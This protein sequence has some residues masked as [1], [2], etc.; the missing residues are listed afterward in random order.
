M[1]A[2]MVV[3]TGCTSKRR[4]DSE[5]AIR[6]S[7]IAEMQDE[8]R[9]MNDEIAAREDELN[10]QRA[11]L[12]L[13]DDK[14]DV[15]EEELARLQREIDALGNRVGTEEQRVDMLNQ[16]LQ[17]VLGDLQQKEKLWLQEKEGMSTITMPNAATFASGST[18]LT[19]EGRAIIDTIWTVLSKYP[20]RDVFIE[21]HTDSIPIGPALRRRFDSNWELSAAR[22]VAVLRYVL[23][24]HEAEAGR[25]GAVGYGEHHP[26]ASNS[27]EETRTLNRRVV[28]SVRPER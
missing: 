17:R 21:G 5:I 2:M 7:T 26:V 28:I 14:I 15:K 13:R 23:S 16:D 10:R 18:A 11:E 22:A 9:R 27:T 6:E 1:V 25:L 4:M 12:S 24:N 3:L 8:V 20:D 19:T